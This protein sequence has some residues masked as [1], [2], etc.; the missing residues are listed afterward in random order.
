MQ[1][2][3]CD[4]W[5]GWIMN[6]VETISYPSVINREVRGMINPSRGLR[7][8]DSISPYLFFIC[9]EVLSRLIGV[10]E[11]EGKLHGVS[12]CTGAPTITHIFFA[13]DSFS[14]CR[15]DEEECGD[16]KVVLSNYARV[17][18]QEIKT[19]K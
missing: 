18:G 9:A 1:L 14:F 8:G 10:A 11:R 13:A 16:L 4:Q 19:L 17:S 5:V 2:G 6:C 12:I 3:F 15:A 7:Q